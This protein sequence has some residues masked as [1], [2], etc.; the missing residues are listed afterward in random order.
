MVILPEV[1][2]CACGCG[3]ELNPKNKVAR[4]RVGHWA[5]VRVVRPVEDR[6]WESVVC[7]TDPNGCWEWNGGKQN[8]GYGVMCV[9][10]RGKTHALA[11]RISWEL[12]NGP[13]PDGLEVCHNCPGGDNPACVRPDHLWLGTHQENMADS[14]R[15]GRSGPKNHPERMARGLRNGK[16]TKPE[17]TLRGDDHPYR[18]R[19]ELVKR[20]TE[21]GNAVLNDEI[22][23]EIRRLRNSGETLVS[24]AIR[25]SI[26]VSMV[27]RIA[28]RESWAH[29][30]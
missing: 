8:K 22:V 11:H 29:V 24:I 30:E 7:S 5:R 4:F 3:E 18:K 27:S 26:H 10:A 16:Y 1:R 15:K 13:I 2:L 19:P 9:A 17:S 21:H 20:G 23:R 25:F 14:A 12:A 28:R 6:F